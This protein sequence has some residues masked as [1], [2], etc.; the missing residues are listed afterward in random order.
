MLAETLGGFGLFLDFL[1]IGLAV[2][3]FLTICDHRFRLSPDARWRHG[4][5]PPP[6]RESRTTPHEQAPLYATIRGPY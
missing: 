1:L 3:V 4:R 6:S 2:A 5:P